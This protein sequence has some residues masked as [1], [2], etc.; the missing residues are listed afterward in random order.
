MLLFHFLLDLVIVLVSDCYLKTEFLSHRVAI[1]V[2][3]Q[4]FAGL[5]ERVMLSTLF[6]RFSFRSTQNIDDLHLSS[7][8]ILRSRV[9]IEM[10]IKRRQ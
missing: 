3:G 9:P 4:R 7:D 1:L 5:E 10:F 2:L 6:R 8:L